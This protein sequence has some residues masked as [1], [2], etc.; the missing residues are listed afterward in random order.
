MSSGLAVGVGFTPLRVWCV[1]WRGGVWWWGMSL[2]IKL[3]ENGG[4][5]PEAVP[6]MPAGE[7]EIC[8][9]V[10]GAPGRRVVVADEAAAERLNVDLQEKLQAAAEK[11][12]ARPLLMFDHNVNGGAAAVPVGFEWDDERGILLRVEWTQA[13]REAVEGGTYGYVS[14]SFRLKAGGSEILGLAEGVEIG[15]LVNDPAFERNECIAASKCEAEDVV[16]YAAN[17]YGCNQHGHE[18]VAEHGEGWGGG[19]GGDDTLDSIKKRK[20]DIGYKQQEVANELVKL[21]KQS[22]AEKDLEKRKKINAKIAEVSQKK[23]KLM[24]QYRKLA[25]KETELKDRERYEK[26]QQSKKAAQEFANM[27]LEAQKAKLKEMEDGARKAKRALQRYKKG[28]YGKAYTVVYGMDKEPEEADWKRFDDADNELRRL[29]DEADKANKVIRDALEARW[30]KQGGGNKSELERM[31]SRYPEKVKASSAEDS[32]P[33]QGEDAEVVESGYNEGTP[34]GVGLEVNQ[35]KKKDMEEIA[36]LLGLPADAD[37]ATICAKIAALKNQGA[38]DKKRIE[39]VEAEKEE[40]KKALTEHK[41]AAADAFVERQKKEGKIAPMDKERCQAARDMY[42]S[43]PAGAECIF[44][45]MKRVDNVREDGKADKVSAAANRNYE[46]L[47][48]A[49]LLA[50]ENA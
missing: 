7:S 13:G 36:K 29:Q 15:S 45:G 4:A 6:Y 17:P 30:K 34:G 18:W 35:N 24:E 2:S 3:S 28:E 1:R 23:Q 42:L 14:P 39:E 37:A 11:R 46:N 49:E 40:H 48:L 41:H 44:A 22:V 31:L 32:L 12:K 38:A 10:N 50:E 27:G 21:G 43:N 25:M 47:S 8:A 9:T 5:A 16:V 20:I 19:A 26:D 33:P